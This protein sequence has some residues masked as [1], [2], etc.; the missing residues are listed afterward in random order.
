MNEL[1]VE[2]FYIELIEQFPCENKEQ[3]L[4][5]EGEY[6]RKMATLNHQTQGRTIQE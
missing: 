4:A 1:G 3:L 6:I 2:N 5:K